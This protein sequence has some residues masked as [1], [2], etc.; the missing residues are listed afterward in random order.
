MWMAAALAYNRVPRLAVSAADTDAT[1]TG[2]ANTSPAD[3]SMPFADRIPPRVAYGTYFL[4]LA[5]A[6]MMGFRYEVGGDWSAYLD[7]YDQVQLLSFSQA[8]G[9]FDTGYAT[10]EF[11]AGRLGAGIWLVNLC[12]ALIMTF[13]IVRFCARQP[14]PALSFLVAIPYLVI[15]VG[16]GYTRQGVAIG[17]ILAALADTGPRADSHA[18]PHA[19]ENQAS[20]TRMVL[21][22]LAAAL[23]HRTAL[24]VMPFVLLPVFRRNILYAICG[25]LVFALL[26]YLLLGRSTDQLITNYVDADYESSGAVVRVAMNVVPAILALT[27]RRR[28][29]YSRYQSDIW[30]ILALVALATVP[31]VL[32]ASFTTAIDRLALFLIPLQIAILPRI[33]YIFGASTVPGGRER[34]NAQLI[35]AVCGYSA[36]VQLVWLVFATHARLWVPYQ[37]YKF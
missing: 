17:L 1:E 5:T 32:T 23:F 12:C 24:L 7:N 31:L 14:N 15:V 4:V 22:I 10:L 25:G 19:G 28:L 9:S 36:A 3:T 18:G 35:L 20:M 33:P 34:M 2:P 26:F 29:G 8:L 16:M 27:L 37:I 13:G 11:V 30:S 21:Y 6:L